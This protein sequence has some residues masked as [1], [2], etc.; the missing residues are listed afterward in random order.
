MAAKDRTNLA[1]AGCLVSH[2]RKGLDHLHAV[3]E[4]FLTITDRFANWWGFTQWSGV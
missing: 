2:L 3:R 4:R 1:G